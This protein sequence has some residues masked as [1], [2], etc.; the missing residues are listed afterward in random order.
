MK[1][2]E[3][4]CYVRICIVKDSEVNIKVYNDSKVQI[5]SADEATGTC[6]LFND[7]PGKETA[8]AVALFDNQVV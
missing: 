4:I 5:D 8:T 2:R 1:G 7:Q 3:E 6:K